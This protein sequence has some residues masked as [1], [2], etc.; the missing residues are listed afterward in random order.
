MTDKSFYFDGYDFDAVSA[1]LRMRYSYESG[2]A[3]E[4]V[5]HFPA[6]TRDL[7]EEDKR[8]IDN[9][10][11]LIFLLA[12]V[13][14]YKA[15]VPTHLVCKAFPLDKATASFIETVY[16]HGLGEFAY[17]NNLDLRDKIK[18]EAQDTDAPTV[19]TPNLR[20]ELCIPVGGGK[21]SVV[22]IEA[23]KKS[24]KPA[25]LFVLTSPAGIAAPIQG[26]IDVSGIPAAKVVRTISPAL[27]ALN[28]EGVYNGHVPITAILS[29]IATALCLMQG[30]STLVMSNE[31]SASAP[32][33]RHHDMDVNHQYSKSL[34]FEQDFSVYLS[35]HVVKGF[36]Y[37]SLLRPLSEAPIVKRFVAH[38]AYHPVFRSCNTA[39][40]Q[41]AAQ[42]GK[43]WCCDCPKCRFVFLAMA[44]F[45]LPS[46]LA[47]IFGKNMLD[48][49][50]QTQ[51]FADLCGFGDYKPFECV[52][53]EEESS[54]LL[55]K[56]A[57]M[58]EWKESRV[59]SAL[60]GQLPDAPP[61][62]SAWQNLLEYRTPHLVPPEYMRY[63]DENG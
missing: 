18:I 7:D 57:T 47:G 5:V 44:P 10:C 20:D 26:C 4:E 48:D 36:K 59:V 17:R 58:P 51:G 28:K 54:L 62:D 45:M 33:L 32:N 46:S 42:R 2:P 19:A 15:Y 3:F 61:F 60:Q 43:N 35:A 14:Y 34:S 41:D 52:G 39:F 63:L 40:K 27:I 31:H 30:W 6:I 55:R 50:T 12:G 23:L 29:A 16:R 49:E 1:T 8:A 24:G 53:E 37:F 22:S 38:T 13:S 21:D 9:A 25:H 56:I 11:R